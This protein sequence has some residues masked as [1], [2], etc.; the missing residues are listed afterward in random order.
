[1]E[2]VLANIISHLPFIL[3]H[4]NKI[5]IVANNESRVGTLSM[6]F[7]VCIDYNS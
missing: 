1:M 7:D 6:H 5:K 3:Y 2:R 4:F